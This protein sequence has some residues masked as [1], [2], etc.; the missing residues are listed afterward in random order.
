MFA[1]NVNND[2]LKVGERNAI[3]AKKKLQEHHIRLLAEDCGLN[4]GRTVEFYSETGDY[5]IKAVG[6]PIKTIYFYEDFNNE[7]KEISECSCNCYSFGRVYN[8]CFYD[9]QSIF[10][11][12]I[13]VGAGISNDWVLYIWLNHAYSIKYGVSR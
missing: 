5:V 9:Y 8:Q 13:Y 4:Y 12:K 10:F 6:K 7:V 2:S 11:D 3:A 1:I